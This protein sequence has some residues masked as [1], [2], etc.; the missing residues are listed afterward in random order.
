M[1]QF[2]FSAIVVVVFLALFGTLIG[3]LFKAAKFL[4]ATFWIPVA[5]LVA[6]AVLAYFYVG[7]F[8]A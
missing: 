5:I 4:A 8:Y 3:S 7:V 6:T 2:M 1:I